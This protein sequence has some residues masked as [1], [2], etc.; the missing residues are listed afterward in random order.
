MHVNNNRLKVV[1]LSPIIKLSAHIP[2]II[3]K[4]TAEWIE[5]LNGMEMKFLSFVMCV[6][7]MTY[8]EYYILLFSSF[9]FCS[10]LSSYRLSV[11]LYDER[12][13]IYDVLWGY[14]SWWQC[15]TDCLEN[16]HVGKAWEICFH[17]CKIESYVWLVQCA[18]DRM[19][20]FWLF[21]LLFIVMAN[22]QGSS[23]T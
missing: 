1:I 22:L 11:N 2:L 21:L 17:L 20:C 18:Y 12:M 6:H 19:V 14:V 15:V 10:I 13:R 7:G 8:A 16:N 5:Q 9:S 23:H 4:L 3:G